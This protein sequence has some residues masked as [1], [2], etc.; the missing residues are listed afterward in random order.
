M[1]RRDKASSLHRLAVEWSVALSTSC[2]SVS[3][4]LTASFMHGLLFDPIIFILFFMKHPCSWLLLC[5]IA[6]KSIVCKIHQLN[7]Q[8][9]YKQKQQRPVRYFLS[10]YIFSGLSSL[11][12]VSGFITQ[13]QIWVSGRVLVSSRTVCIFRFSLFLIMLYLPAELVK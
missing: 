10:V 12:S 2:H 9:C 6:S 13:T 3:S 11:Y 5:L 7:I 4:N 1:R 8:E